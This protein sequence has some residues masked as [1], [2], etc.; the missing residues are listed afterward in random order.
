MALVEGV[1]VHL[2]ALARAVGHQ[3]SVGEECGDA[4]EVGGGRVVALEEELVHLAVGE[5]VEQDGAGG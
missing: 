4:G 2:E 5:G 1:E 3:E